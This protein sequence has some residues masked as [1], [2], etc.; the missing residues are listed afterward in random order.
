MRQ[1]SYPYICDEC[2]MEMRE[3]NGPMVEWLNHNGSISDVRIVHAT[4][5]SPKGECYKHTH[6]AHRR[7]LHIQDVVG[8]AELLKELSL[9]LK[10]ED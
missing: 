4:M 6:N 9:K 5:H 8:D 3:E 1:I 7:D 10:T 2:G